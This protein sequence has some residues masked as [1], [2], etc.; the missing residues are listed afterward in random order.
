MKKYKIE[1]T[2][3]DKYIVDVLAVD[4]VS[5]EREALK[6]FAGIVTSGIA[7]Y[8]QNGDTETGV[9]NAFDATGTDDPFN[10]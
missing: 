9:S 5:A 10:P 7:H 8:Y 4:Q 6:K 3:S 1:I 2:Q